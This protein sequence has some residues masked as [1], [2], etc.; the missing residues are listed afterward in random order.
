MNRARA[1]G[2]FLRGFC[3]GAADAVPGVSGGTI[4]LITGVYDRLVAAIANADPR[5]LVHLLRSYDYE[6]RSMARTQLEA[7]DLPFLLLLGIGVLS[8][9]VSVAQVIEVALERHPE[10]LF[11]FFFGLI[12]ASA[13]ALADDVDV[14]RRRGAVGGAAGVVLALALTSLPAFTLPHTLPVLAV[15]G[16]VAICAMV[17]P[18]VS[19][20]LLLLLL[21]QYHYMIERLNAV[22]DTVAAL[23]DGGSPS[24]LVG[25]AV[26][27]VT[28]VAGAF[29]GLLTVSRVVEWALEADRRATITFLVG[30]MVGAL[31]LPVAEV[32]GAVAA[33]TPGVAV[34]V[35]GAAVVGAALILAFDAY[36][37]VDY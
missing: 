32:H 7:M 12:A 30:L 26:P 34:G 19:G 29:V 16:A 28:F 4:A 13:Y 37:G 35:G 25:P 20:S 15:V 24:S 9:V 18:G 36:A 2:I 1:L 31:W 27:V 8:A 33:W 6:H 11:A 23:A 14:R 5:V 17:L 21:G 3:M 22:V 10:Y